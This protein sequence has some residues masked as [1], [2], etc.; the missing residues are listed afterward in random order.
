MND[1]TITNILGLQGTTL[2]FKNNVLDTSTTQTI[3]GSKTFNTN[4]QINAI[5]KSGNIITIPL[6]TTT[7]VGKDTVDIL[8]NKEIDTNSNSIFITSSPLTSV[9]INTLIN[10]DVRTTSSPTFVTNNLTNKLNIDT[11]IGQGI[12]LNC[13]NNLIQNNELSL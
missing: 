11:T 12:I 8:L 5:V 13:T 3:T 4:P 9:D 10:Q 1:N 6:S 7:L 2:V